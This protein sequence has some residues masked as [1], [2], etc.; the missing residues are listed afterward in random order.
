LTAAMTKAKEPMTGL[1]DM[2]VSVRQVFGIDSDLEVPA[3]SEVDPHVPDTDPDYRFD[4]PT[5]L[6][7]LA[8]F[9]HNRRVMVTGFHGTGKSTHIEQVAAR[10]NWPCVRVNLDSHIS[11][12]DL[13]GKDPIHSRD[14]KPGP[15]PRIFARAT[16]AHQWL[17]QSVP[18]AKYAG[19]RVRLK[20]IADCGPDDN[21]V[22]DH[23]RWGDIKIIRAGTGQAQTAPKS[24]MTWVNNRAFPAAFY[25]RDIRS[26]TVDFNFK[27]EGNEQV[28]IHYLTAH[29]HPDAI[30]RAFVNGLV[31]ANPS[32]KPYF[33]DLQTI[34]PGR[35]FTRI[36]SSPSQDPVTNNGQPI[37]ESITLAPLDALFLRVDHQSNDGR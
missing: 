32:A 18:L 25:F 20:F 17:E 31:V 14:G 22:T 12:I 1:P 29:A 24:H 23:G 16:K 9:A 11:R 5:T 15:V 34:A 27:I 13:V 10:L 6:A 28:T 35:K 19:K 4:R 36:L 37:G 33:F 2:K 30:Y 8:G 3:Y 21:A 7:I 26:A